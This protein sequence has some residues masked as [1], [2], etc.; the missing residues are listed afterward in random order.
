MKRMDL[1]NERWSDEA[2][3]REREK[4]LALWP[5]GKDVD[6]AEAVEFHK[7]LPAAKNYAQAVVK[8]KAEGRTL[9]QPRGGV[10]LVDDHIKLLR[11]LQDQGDADLLPTTTDTYTRNQRF[12]EAQRGIEASRR[13][14]RSMLNGLPVVNH[15]V[16]EVRRVVQAVDR[17]VMILSGTPFPRLTAEVALAAGFTGFLGAGI[18]YPTSYIKEMPIE[19]GIKSYQYLD[20]LVSFYAEHGVMIHREQPGFLTGTLIPPGIGIAI[21]VMEVLLAAGQGLRHYSVGL[22]QNLDLAQDVAALQIMEELCHAYL[23]RL[24]YPEMFISVATHQWMQAFPSDDAKAYAVIAMGG[25]IAALAGATQVITK[26]THESTGIPTMIANAE[27]VRATKMAV[28]L[29]RNRKLP[30]DSEIAGEMEIIRKEA[31]AILDKTL[32]MGDGDVAVGAVRGFEAGIIDVPWA[33]NA[34]V[35]G[36]VIPVRDAQGAV[37]YLE[38][39]NLPFDNDLKAYHREKLKTRER[40]DGKAPDYETAMFDIMEL[41][42]FV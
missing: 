10:A 42:Q 29:M 14:G 18:S 16:Q 24:N 21:A 38:F 9:V 26:T 3:E 28:N 33:P 30:V 40:R 20:R 13:A 4:T 19:E 7:N 36:Q 11:C 6:L 15:G 32:E 22:C 23:K 2:F 37:R 25:I 31:R 1:K 8:A 35:K 39:G 41:S 17:P 5:T 27:G 34:H 12:Q